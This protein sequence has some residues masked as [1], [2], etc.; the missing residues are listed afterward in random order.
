MHTMKVFALSRRLIEITK[1]PVHLRIRPTVGLRSGFR[2]A[3]R[4]LTL[5][6][7]LWKYVMWPALERLLPVCN[8]RRS[9]LTR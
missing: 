1:T 9:L 7:M 6:R 2:L 5:R 3:L 4:P 8:L